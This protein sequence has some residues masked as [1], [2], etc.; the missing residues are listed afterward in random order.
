[1]IAEAVPAV[2]LLAPRFL[3]LLHDIVEALEEPAV[4]EGRGLEDGENLLRILLRKE[5]GVAVIRLDAVPFLVVAGIIDELTAFDLLVERREEEV[6]ENRPVVAA[7]ALDAGRGGVVHLRLGIELDERLLEERP[8]KEVRVH[9]S[10]LL[11]EPSEHHARDEADQVLTVELRIVR[12]VV[13]V[14]RKRDMLVFELR[15]EVPVLDLVVELLGELLNGERLLDRRERR[16][17]HRHALDERGIAVRIRRHVEALPL[18]AIV[19][20][21]AVLGRRGDERDAE[22]SVA[23]ME[24]EDALSQEPLDRHGRIVEERLQYLASDL[25]LADAAGT[26]GQFLVAEVDVRDQQGGGQALRTGQV[27]D[28]AE[29]PDFLFRAL[30]KLDRNRLVRVSENRR[31]AAQLDDRGELLRRI[32]LYQLTNLV[33]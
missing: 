13:E 23:V 11:Q 33:F 14:V 4:H 31:S 17:V 16:P 2:G 21:R 7:L 22:M 12:I 26:L 18:R 5:L 24:S 3:V 8:V 20:E 10:F 28:N 29:D 6:L 27:G 25:E 30:F 32:S 9:E 1:M 15:P 19:L